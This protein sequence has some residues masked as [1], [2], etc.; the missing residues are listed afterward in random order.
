ME[1]NIGARIVAALDGTN[2]EKDQ[3]SYKNHVLDLSIPAEEI[4]FL[5]SISGQPT[6]PAGEL[7]GVKGRAKVGKSQFEYFLI[8]A[9]LAGRERGSV[10]P[11]KA[12]LKALL[13]D[14]EQSQAS[15]KKCCKRALN[16]AGMPTNENHPNFMPFFLRP[17]SVEDRKRVIA[18]AIREER[19]NIVFIDGIRDLLNDFNNLEQ[20]GSLIQWLMQLTTDYG[21]TVVNVLHQNKSKDDSSMRGHLGTELLNKLCDCF[22]VTKKSGKFV[23][24]CTDSRN[25]P[26]QDFAFSIDAY[27]FFQA[28]D[29][30]NNAV[31]AVA[32]EV[33]RVLPLC[34]RE[35]SKLKYSDLV[36]RYQEE[37][38]VSERTAKNRI[39]AAKDYDLLVVIEGQYSLALNA[40]AG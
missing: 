8:G 2:T 4:Q 17:L 35:H 13:F 21:C 37:A 32:G 15:L 20:S 40:G 5:F 29:V 36:Q 12:N 28:E 18:D 34:F 9:M 26:T 30:P 3:F 6:I 16:L 39:K 23:V 1:N 14:T 11:L 19:P 27:G 38:A 22:E 33:R 10:K 25:I 31:S 7:I 24:S